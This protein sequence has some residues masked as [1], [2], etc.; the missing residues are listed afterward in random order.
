MNKYG[1]CEAIDARL[2]TADAVAQSLRQHGDHAVR[3][4]NAVSAPARFSI[5][6]AVGLYVSGDISNVDAE[7][8]TAADLLN[9]NRVVEIA[10]VIGIDGDDEFS[11]Q[12]FASL[13]LPGVDCLR[14]PFRLVQTVAGKCCR[15]MVFPD[16]RDHADSG[17]GRR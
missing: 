5:Q 2:E 1:M 7:P 14:N 17:T 4:V 10:R 12:I 11:A 8:P 15:Q 13:K 9:M 6:R 16:H 3:E